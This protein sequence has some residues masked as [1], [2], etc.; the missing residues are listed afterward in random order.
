MLDARYSANYVHTASWLQHCLELFQLSVL[1]R[2]ILLSLIDKTDAVILS[3]SHQLRWR[4]IAARCRRSN[5]KWLGHCWNSR[6][7]HNAS[8]FCHCVQ[9]YCD[10]C[11]SD[12]SQS[13]PCYRWSPAQTSKMELE[14][15]WCHQRV[16]YSWRPDFQSSSWWL[17]AT[18]FWNHNVSRHH[19]LTNWLQPQVLS[20]KGKFV[21]RPSYHL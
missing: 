12:D 15:R 5:P 6:L 4:F 11:Q 13:N 14:G 1:P 20:K 2:S 9:A 10:L 17:S 7:I 18:R 16:I 21:S 19:C 3:P 8:R